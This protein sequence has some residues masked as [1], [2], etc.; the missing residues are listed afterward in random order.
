MEENHFILF[1]K[2]SPLYQ[3]KETN[4]SFPGVTGIEHDPLP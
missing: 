2:I 1:V 4:G 3:V